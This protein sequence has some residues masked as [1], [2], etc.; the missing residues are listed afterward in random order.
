MRYKWR[1]NTYV[2]QRPAP[3]RDYPYVRCAELRPQCRHH[4]RAGDAVRTNRPI[5]R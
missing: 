1:P 3:T 5:A 2:I 4:E